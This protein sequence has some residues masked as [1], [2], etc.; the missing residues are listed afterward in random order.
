[1]STGWGDT[2]WYTVPG[3]DHPLWLTAEQAA[4]AN[5]VLVDPPAGDPDGSP[6]DAAIAALAGLGTSDFRAAEDPQIRQVVADDISTDGTVIADA[7]S[8]AYG[9]VVEHGSTAGTARPTTSLGVRWEGTVAPTNAINGDRWLNTSTGDEKVK[10]S[11]SFI[12]LNKANNDGTYVSFKTLAKN[13]DEL[14]TGSIT[15]DTNG[16]VTSAAVV[17]PDG[18]PGTF[19]TDTIGTSNT[20]DGYH[21][22][23][24][25]PATKT[26]TQPTITRDTSGAATNVPA[27]VV[28]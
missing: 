4:A 2:D 25:S 16:V 23:Y 21:I 17:W 27:I 1:M 19:T 13:P 5:G 14:I 20:I 8:S 10:I 22:T 18:T 12:A 15:R 24:G 3:V 28:T 9:A 6:L 7:L 11:G 26:Y